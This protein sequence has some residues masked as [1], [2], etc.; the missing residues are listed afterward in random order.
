MVGQEFRVD[1]STVALES[2]SESLVTVSYD[3]KLLEY[4]RVGP[5]AAAI[6]ARAM[7]GQVLLTVRRQGTTE[8]GSRVLAM[9]FFQ[10]KA[11]GDA[12]LTM[13][14]TPNDGALPAS[15]GRAVVHVQ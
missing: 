13:G 3:P 12:T 1:L 4:R 6:S 9:L 14:V 15:T 2:L 11:K 8:T 5:G 10:A 7:D